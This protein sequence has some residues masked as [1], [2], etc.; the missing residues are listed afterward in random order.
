[1]RTL[2]IALWHRFLIGVN[3]IVVWLRFLTGV[4][5]SRA[6]KE[7]VRVGRR[8]DRNVSPVNASLRGGLQKVR[9][10]DPTDCGVAP[11]S[12]RC[13]SEPRP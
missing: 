10:A 8:E 13:E 5:Q 11:V 7:A 4:N 1:M 2:R 3:R 9:S 6:R 12:N